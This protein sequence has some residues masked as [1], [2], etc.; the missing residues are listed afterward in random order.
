MHII[1]NIKNINL[2]DDPPEYKHKIQSTQQIIITVCLFPLVFVF[3]C[4]SAVASFSPQVSQLLELSG[5]DSISSKYPF[6]GTQVASM[7]AIL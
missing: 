1:Q 6:Y 4:F 7:K 5:S 2:Q 3:T